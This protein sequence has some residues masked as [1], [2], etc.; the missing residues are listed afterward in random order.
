MLA[1]LLPGLVAVGLWGAPAAAGPAAAAAPPANLLAEYNPGF[2]DELN[3]LVGWDTRGL[4]VTLLPD[5]AAGAVHSGKHALKIECLAEQAYSNYIRSYAQISVRPGDTVR[6]AYWVRGSGKFS[7]GLFKMIDE[8][9]RLTRKTVTGKGFPHMVQL[10][11]QWRRE[12]FSYLVEDNVYAVQPL[13][14]VPPAKKYPEIHGAPWFVVLDDV[15][16]VRVAGPNHPLDP[17]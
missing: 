13:F 17:G 16:V 6:V 12:G 5:A 8:R 1:A 11:G 2:E 3:P 9:D 15:S 14:Y 7:A 4:P 10:A